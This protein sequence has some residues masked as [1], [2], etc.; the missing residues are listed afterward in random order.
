MYSFGYWGCGQATKALVRAFKA[1]EYARGLKAPLWVDIRLQR[2]CRAKGF[3]GIAF[4]TR[5][6]QQYKWIPDLGNT[7]IADGT[8]GINIKNPAAAGQLLD[9]ALNRDRHVIFFCACQHPT[10][11]HR[12][13]VGQLLIKEARTRCISMEVVEWPGMLPDSISLNVARADLWKA[14]RASSIDLNEPGPLKRLGIPKSMGHARAA[15][16]PWGTLAEL[17]AEGENA[18]ALVG[19]ARF[20]VNGPY[21]PVIA[22]AATD[23]GAVRKARTWRVENGYELLKSM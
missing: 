21:L 16:I 13:K 18:F 19:P 2:T 10:G 5:L 9:L 12:Q 4:K 17:K 8:D 22:S 20:G 3:S 7:C 15:I 6:G 14:Q 1:A 11:C 23:K